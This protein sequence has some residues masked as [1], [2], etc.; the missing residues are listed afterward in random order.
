MNETFGYEN[1]HCFI[2]SQRRKKNTIKLYVNDGNLG[3]FPRKKMYLQKKI[4]N[5]LE[6]HTK[7]KNKHLS[8]NKYVLLHNQLHDFLNSIQQYCFIF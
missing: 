4:Q 1:H 6:F 3:D 8:F 2:F 7:S 5:S